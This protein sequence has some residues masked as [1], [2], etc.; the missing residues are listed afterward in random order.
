MEKGNVFVRERVKLVEFL[1]QKDCPASGQKRDQSWTSKVNRGASQKILGFQMSAILSVSV[2]L[3]C[4]MIDWLFFRL[5]PHLESR[6]VSRFCSRNLSP[7]SQILQCWAEWG[8]GA[9]RLC[10]VLRLVDKNNFLYWSCHLEWALY[11]FYQECYLC[12][13]YGGLQ[14]M[15]L[16]PW[17]CVWGSSSALSY[18]CWIPRPGEACCLCPSVLNFSPSVSVAWVLWPRF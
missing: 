15:L 13:W 3:R 17:Q 7:R 6:S 14:D 10:H 11:L 16:V 5:I 8:L 4:F 18:A 1:K 2:F 9:G 12:F